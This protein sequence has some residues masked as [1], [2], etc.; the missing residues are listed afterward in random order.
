MDN[1]RDPY[2]EIVIVAVALA[3]PLALWWAFGGDLVYW[4][5]RLKLAELRLL[6]ALGLGDARTAELT[7]ALRGALGAPDRLS[8]ATFL[9]GLDAVGRYWRAPV[10]LAL[11]GLGGWLL[12]LHPAERFRRRFD[13]ARLAET[14]GEQWPFA[15]HALR[16]GQL[17]IPLDDPRWGMALSAR[18]FVERHG[19]LQTDPGPILRHEPTLQVLVAQLGAP[20]TAAAAASP[21]VRAL[22]GVFAM[23][24]ASL[25]GEEGQAAERLKQRTFALLRDLAA[26][27]AQHRAGDYLPPAAAYR[28]VIQ[29][30]APHWPAAQALVARHAYTQTVLLRLLAEARQGGVLP[31]A[32]F[33]WLKGVDRPLWYALSSLGRRVPFAEA[34]GAMAHYQ[35]ERAA[36]AALPQPCVEAAVE[37]LRADIQ[38]PAPAAVTLDD[39]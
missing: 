12:A 30:T 22:A 15:L 4:A 39:P 14:I 31:P 27:A 5:F 35:A 24:V 21:P 29:E 37:A 13:L 11:I 20:W 28:A 6:E 19:L 10:C 36:D 9:F 34:L 1:P 3:V 32:L 38:P 26:A 23:R 16:R 18:E 7:H 8:F 17:D 25:T 33:A 2:D